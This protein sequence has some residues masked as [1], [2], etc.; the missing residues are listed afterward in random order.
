MNVVI[1]GASQGIGRACVVKFLEHGYTVHGLDIQGTDV[2]SAN[3]KHTLCDV[4][5]RYELP[6]IPNVYILVNCAGVQNS[7]K[8]IDVN[9]RGVMNC[10]EKYGLQ[11]DIHA[12]VNQG[13]AAA[14]QGINFPEYVASKGGV[15]AYTKWAA[16]EVAKYGATCNSLSFGGVITELNAPVIDQLGLWNKIMELT[17]L[18]KWATPA[19]VAEWVYFISVLNR[20]CSGQDIIIDN[21]ESL[22]SE[23]IWTK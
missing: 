21:L 18:K 9:L 11:E 13:D 14:H 3:Y 23:F 1:T 15:I 4:S 16:K 10:T 20:S 19:E 12:I 5:N 22:N 2:V 8:D 7:G 6:D 17:P